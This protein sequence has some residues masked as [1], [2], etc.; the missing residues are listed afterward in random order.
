[1][2]L[3]FYAYVEERGICV[4]SRC[5]ATREEKKGDTEEEEEEEEEKDEVERGWVAGTVS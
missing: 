4:R 3:L 5:V 2:R 1:M